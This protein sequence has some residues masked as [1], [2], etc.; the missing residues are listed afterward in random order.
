MG[1][2]QH[3]QVIDGAVAFLRHQPMSALFR[4]A[5]GREDGVHPND[6]GYRLLAGLAEAY[7]GQR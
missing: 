2:Q 6:A 5:D 3:V 4:H 1:E 7:L